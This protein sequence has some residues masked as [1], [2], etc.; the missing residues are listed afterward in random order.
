MRRLTGE[1]ARK[2]PFFARLAEAWLRIAD[3]FVPA[4]TARDREASNQARMFLIS[5]TIGP[6][7]G[8]TVPIA[9]FIFD[10]TPRIDVLIL[11]LSISL[12]WVFP[13]LLRWGVAYDRLVVLSV[14]NLNFAILWSC[15]H[16][17]GVAS[18]TLTWVLII[19]ILS[20]FYVG[21]ERRLQ[22]W[23][24][25]VTA[26]SLGIFFGTYSW[27]RPPPN[28][29]PAAAMLG[30]GAVSMVA[31]L[32]YVA[33]MAVYY[34]RVFDAGV[35]LEIEVRRRRAMADELRRAVALA[36]RTGSAKSE[37]L[38]RMSHEIRTPLNAIIGYGQLLKEEAEEEDDRAMQADVARI[39]DAAHY[40]VR[41][42][43][44]ILDLAKIEAGR[45]S[46]DAQPHRVGAL[47]E[48]AV[49]ARRDLIDD[50]KNRVGIEV[51]PGLDRVE[52]DGHRFLQIVDA[53]L[54]NAALHTD[55][56]AIVLTASRDP[57]GKPAFRVA[58]ADTGNGIPPDRMATLFN[59]FAT[60]QS[61]AGGRYG[62]TGLNLA[63]CHQLCHAMGGS[64]DV[65]S[66]PGAGT[67]ITVTMPLAGRRRPE[68]GA[69]A[70]GAEFVPA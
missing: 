10:P 38:A 18:P 21:G 59:T 47:L 56:G 33:T 62:G 7:L 45:M 22:P 12:F 35:D 1:E 49:A 64:I 67:T 17:G 6:V 31:T 69:S 44:M 20:L 60:A 25:G 19:P 54:E 66:A 30:L 53:I 24:L 14:V 8:N 29:V 50:R 63:V 58:V 5:H 15:Y 13:F 65:R 2:R 46:F 70:A 41:L 57:A 9:L 34:A 16:Y 23:L 52:I 27:L 36:H 40:L 48:K 37:F 3:Y 28:D 26:V 11:A 32:A 39:L 42:I 68:D 61:A 51:G 55:G 4:A 43:N